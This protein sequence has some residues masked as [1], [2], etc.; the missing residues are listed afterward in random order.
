MG[1]IKYIPSKKELKELGFKLDDDDHYITEITANDIHGMVF[2][3]LINYFKNKNI[4][5]MGAAFYFIP[6]SFEDLKVIMR[7]FGK[8]VNDYK[9]KLS[10]I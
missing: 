9:N 8:N 7:I 3:C 5:L 2:P 10:F 4:F 1:K 6:D